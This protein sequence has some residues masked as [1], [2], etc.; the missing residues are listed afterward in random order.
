[1]IFRSPWRWRF[2]VL[3]VAGLRKLLKPFGG[4]ENR[5]IRW[6]IEV[7]NRRVKRHLSA[8]RIGSVLL[9]LPRCLK[10]THC[11]EHL[12]IKGEPASLV[13]DAAHPLLAKCPDCKQCLLGDVAELTQGFGV[14][15]LVAYRSHIAYSIA[16]KL[17]PDLILATA[18]EDRLIKAL[19]SVPEIPALLTPLVAMEQMCVNAECDLSWFRRQLELACDGPGATPAL[20]DPISAADSAEANPIRSAEG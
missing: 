7:N 4:A 17:K 15:A 3:G 18:C 20:A 6:V 19:R 12:R 14:Q 13:P 1:M 10:P 5:L 2:F 11:R 8:R 16:R 9:I